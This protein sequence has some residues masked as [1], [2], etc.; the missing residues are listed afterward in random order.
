MQT[1]SHFVE[2]KWRINTKQIINTPPRLF[3]DPDVWV[4]ME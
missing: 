3:G 1:E 4:S 2:D